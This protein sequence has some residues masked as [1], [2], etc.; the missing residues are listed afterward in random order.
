MSKQYA[1]LAADIVRLV[2]GKANITE[3]YHCQTRLRFALKDESAVALDELNATEGIVKTLSKGGVFQVVV[4]MHVKDVFDEMEHELGTQL[5]DGR[6]EGI[7]QR[8]A[9]PGQM[10]VRDDGDAHRPSLGLRGRRRRRR[11]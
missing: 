3:A 8:P 4:G 5:A 11:P 2:G 10:R 9:E 1:P 7:G 6:D